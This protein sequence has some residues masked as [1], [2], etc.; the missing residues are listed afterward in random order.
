MFFIKIK[1][2]LN[3]Y[4]VMHTYVTSPD[5]LRPCIWSVF[6]LC[7]LKV[8]P[9]SITQN[10]LHLVRSGNYLNVGLKLNCWL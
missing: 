7:F 6:N 10:S 9:V 4:S 2:I 3:I 8:R 1:T 5:R